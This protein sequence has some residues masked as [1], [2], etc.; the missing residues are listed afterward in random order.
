MNSPTIF[1]AEMHDAVKL[2]DRAIEASFSQLT[3]N[4]TRLQE[5]LQNQPPNMHYYSNPYSNQYGDYGYA[6]GVLIYWGVVLVLALTMVLY[7]VCIWKGMRGNFD[8]QRAIT[9]EP[10][11]KLSFTNPLAP[12]QP[13]QNMGMSTLQQPTNMSSRRSSTSE[14]MTTAD[15]NLGNRRESTV[16]FGGPLGS[17]TK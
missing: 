11:N 3:E 6:T 15:D 7:G 5:K 12:Q 16:P 13:P 17:P 1:F 10:V 9:G 14:I 4:I 2:I 8:L